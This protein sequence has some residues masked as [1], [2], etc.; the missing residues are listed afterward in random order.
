MQVQTAMG[1]HI[2]IVSRST[3]L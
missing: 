1:P 3:H 2:K